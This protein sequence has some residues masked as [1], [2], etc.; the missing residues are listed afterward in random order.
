MGQFEQALWSARAAAIFDYDNPD[1]PGPRRGD[2]VVLM[3]L[4]WKSVAALEGLWRLGGLDVA[5]FVS[6][7]WSLVADR[8]LCN[9]MAERAAAEVRADGTLSA[10]QHYR[11]RTDD[12]IVASAVYASTGVRL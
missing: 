7:L 8:D 12:E 5:G 11:P 2:Q 9:H 10:Q 3:V 6:T 4:N 1:V